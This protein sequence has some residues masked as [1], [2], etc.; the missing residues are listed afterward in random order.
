MIRDII[1]NHLDGDYHKRI[2]DIKEPT[3]YFTKV[4]RTQKGRSKCH[5]LFGK[6]TALST[7]TKTKKKSF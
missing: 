6:G 3:K 1:T 5:T 4:K 2:F 7:K